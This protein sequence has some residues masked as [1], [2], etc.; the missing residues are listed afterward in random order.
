MQTAKHPL[1]LFY[2]YAREDKIFRDELD[3]HLSGLKRQ[4]LL[5]T[6]SDR[7]I[8]AGEEWETA[9]DFHLQSAHLILLLISPLFLAS[10]YCYSKE[11]QQALER[12]KQGTARVIPILVRPTDYENAPFST[13]QMLPT[14]AWPVTL[15][16]NRDAAWLDVVEGIRAVIKNLPL[17]PKTKKSGMKK[18]T[19]STKANS[20]WKR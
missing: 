3:L 18:E 20:L 19:N 14:D 7:E 5:L 6:W 11:M 2:C 9:I 4:Q 13:L 16:P 1:N 10:D 17:S 8:K 15:W 12:H